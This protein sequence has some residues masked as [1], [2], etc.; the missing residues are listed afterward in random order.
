[1]KQ[2]FLVVGIFVGWLGTHV[3]EMAQTPNAE[4]SPTSAN[5]SMPSGLLQHP[6]QVTLYRFELND[7]KLDKFDE[8]MTF[9]QNNL[10]ATVA[11]LERERMYFEAMFRD[12]V[13]QKNVVYWLAV[14]G[15]GGASGD[16]SP[17]EIDKKH[18]EYMKEILKRG[19]RQTL[20][21]EFVLIP[22]F[23]EAAIDQHHKQEK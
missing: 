16:S 21:T 5:T 15:E 2:L 7:D 19:S 10:P 6:L 22:P 18:K 3:V 14:N 12:R 13:N 11:T 9:Y 4:T 20:S 8:W 17:L 1:M 23:I